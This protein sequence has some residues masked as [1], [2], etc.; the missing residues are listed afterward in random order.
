MSPEKEQLAEMYN[1][2]LNKPRNVNQDGRQQ[3]KQG[4]NMNE[5]ADAEGNGLENE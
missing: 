3:A 5:N 1:I 4:S 2:T